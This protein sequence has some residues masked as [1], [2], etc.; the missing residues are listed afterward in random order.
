MLQK[1]YFIL[2]LTIV[3]TY[4][5]AGSKDAVSKMPAG[6]DSLLVKL[7]HSGEDT[8]KVNTLISLADK[9]S[10]LDPSQ[11]FQYANQALVLSKK[12]DFSKG[13]VS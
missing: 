8:V 11:S 6:I 2:F 5:F 4:S 3:F 1:L 12:I 10:S 9:F 13:V 7:E